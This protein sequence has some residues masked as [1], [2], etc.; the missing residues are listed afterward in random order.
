MY[1]TTTTATAAAA[2]TTTAA[3]TPTS[4]FLPF[5]NIAGL[6]FGNFSSFCGG[7]IAGT[8]SLSNSC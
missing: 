1:Y 4:G 3:I 6:K 2:A 8:G 7:P 5:G